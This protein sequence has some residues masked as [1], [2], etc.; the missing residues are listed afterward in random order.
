VQLTEHLADVVEDHDAFTAA[1]AAAK[2]HLGA[3]CFLDAERRT[4][5]ST[6]A[7]RIP[8]LGDRGLA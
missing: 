7:A 4:T 5:G 1:R 6:R 3:D 8:T 2:E